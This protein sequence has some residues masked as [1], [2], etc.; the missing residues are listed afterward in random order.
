MSARLLIE[1]QRQDCQL[2]GIPVY[3]DEGQM[4]Y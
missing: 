3:Y 2:S 4:T 1:S